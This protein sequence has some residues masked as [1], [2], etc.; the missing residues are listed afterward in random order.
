MLKNHLKGYFI[1]LLI[2]LLNLH[3]THAQTPTDSTQKEVLSVGVKEAAPFA[4]KNKAGEW[5][6]ISIYLWK[7]LAESLNYEYEFVEYDLEGLL[8]NVANEQLDA[9]I[10]AITIS[11][12]REEMFD[13]SLPYFTTGLS[14][15]TEKHELSS[16]DILR[17]LFSLQFFQVIAGLV[18]LLF[19]IGALLWLV[20]RKHN[21]EQFG[22][23]AWRGIGAGFW[24]SA[25]TM[26]TVGYGDKAPVTFLGRII[27]FIWM[28]SGI[29]IISGFTAAITS[30]LTVDR[31]TTK[32]QG[33]EDLDNVSVAT[34]RGSSSAIYLHNR[35]ITFLEVEQIEEAIEALEK[36]QV[37]AVVYDAPILQYLICQK[38]KD[39]LELL[40]GVFLPFYYG[41]ALPESSTRKEEINVHLLD[42]ISQSEWK[43]VLFEH[44]GSSDH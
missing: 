21:A 33:P 4:M 11:K 34:V 27:G 39:N 42:I 24:W 23:N 12:E 37:D 6:G 1:I 17:R 28:F 9:G 36:K 8:A 29:I 2:S 20:E 31:L 38:K 30:V 35:E 32:I 25:V 15:V 7:Q 41:I 43:K 18:F 22:G 10:A 13:F 14:I 26:T 16:F 40:P 3:Q 19:I 5:S 44:L